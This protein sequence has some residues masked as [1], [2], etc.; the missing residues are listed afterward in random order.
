MS[1]LSTNAATSDDAHL[2]IVHNL[3]CHRLDGETEDF[4]RRTIEYLVKKLKE[5]QDDLD[6]LITAIT[7]K[8]ADPSNCVR[9]SRS[10]DNRI[11]VSSC[12][13]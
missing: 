10:L 9:I 3:M 12:N 1:G 13:R 4:A 5:R 2:N 8:G 7:T 11:H 6:S